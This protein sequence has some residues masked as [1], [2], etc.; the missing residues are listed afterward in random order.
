MQIQGSKARLK[1]SKAFKHK[2][3]I[4][5]IDICPSLNVTINTSRIDGTNLSGSSCSRLPPWLGAARPRQ[6]K[7]LSYR[8][9]MILNHPCSDVSSIAIEQ[10]SQGMTHALQS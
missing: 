1:R 3:S 7:E 8:R 9:V 5:L 4:V 2:H 10:A 6:G